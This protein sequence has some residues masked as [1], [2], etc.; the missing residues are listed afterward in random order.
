MSL[1]AEAREN[2]REDARAA[3]RWFF[4]AAALIAL[5]GI[6]IAPW[7][8][9]ELPDALVVAAFA[10]ALAGIVADRAIGPRRAAAGRWDLLEDALASDG[11]CALA[12][13]V[14]FLA[15]YAATISP[16]TPYTEP[17]RQAYAFLHGRTWVD[18]PSYMEHVVWHGRSYLLHPPL[19]ALITLPAVAIWGLATN[20]TA[21]SVVV[22]AVSLGL[23]WRLLGKIGLDLAARIWLTLFFGVG[24]TFWYEATLGSSWDFV[25]LATIPFTLGALAEVF[26]EARP[27]VVGLLAALAALARNDM[28]FAWPFYAGLLWLRGR[29]P[30]DLLSMLPWMAAALAVFVA[31]NEARFGTPYDIGMWLWYGQDKYRFARPGGPLALSH[32]P[33]NLY[34]VLFMAPRYSDKFPYIR[35]DFLGQALMLTSPAFVL[36]LRP[37]FLRPTTILVA[38]AAALCAGPGMLWYANGFAQLGARYYVEVYPFLLTLI[39]LGAP[40]KLDQLTKILIV[41]SIVFVVFFTW[42]VRWYGWGG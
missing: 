20:Q 27:W 2:V 13:G 1:G 14:L 29:R 10:L 31:F 3:A 36:A 23:V 12:V 38:L 25:V 33:F 28:I 24:T 5:F 15:F 39:A 32:F 30:R 35:P 16:P 22:G 6:L 40:R 26:G 42:Q 34:T 19:A 11:W 18:A 8:K 7:F 4:V 41:V 9:H 21:I 17:V 37:S